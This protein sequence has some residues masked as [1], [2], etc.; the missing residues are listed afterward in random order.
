MS[1][2]SVI[3]ILKDGKLRSIDAYQFKVFPRIGECIAI[4]EMSSIGEKSAM[5]YQVAHIIHG[6]GNNLDGIDILVKR[7]YDT[8]NHYGINNFY[9]ELANAEI[10]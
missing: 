5:F 7:I 8:A 4:D 10:K 9:K 1:K 6:T 3:E 2:Y